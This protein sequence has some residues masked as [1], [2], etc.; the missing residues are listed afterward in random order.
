M[1]YCS[2]AA[3]NSEGNA[4]WQSMSSPAQ[5]SYTDDL[6]LTLDVIMPLGRPR[7]RLQARQAV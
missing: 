5:F 2:F 3:T 6:F 7:F 4:P 1:R